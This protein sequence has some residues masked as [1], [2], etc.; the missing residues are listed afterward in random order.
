M[1]KKIPKTSGLE[2]LQHSFTAFNGTEYGDRSSPRNFVNSY[3]TYKQ[4]KKKPEAVK[5]ATEHY[6]V[7]IP[8]AEHLIENS[9]GA[10]KPSSSKGL[11]K[12]NNY[13]LKQGSI[14]EYL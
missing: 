4:W 14:W 5:L 9:E 3:I 12:F 2:W 1:G 8:L 13:K 7:L 11:E 6:A 10:G